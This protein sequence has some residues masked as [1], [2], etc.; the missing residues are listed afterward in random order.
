MSLGSFKAVRIV[1][2]VTV[3]PVVRSAHGFAGQNGS[4]GSNVSNDVN[5]S[6][7]SNGSND[8]NVLLVHSACQ[9]PAID[10]EELPGDEAGS[11]RGEEHSGP[12]Q[13]LDV[14]EPAHRRPHQDF[15]TTR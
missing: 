11:V 7:G 5:D 9:E 8:P 4:N 14:T 6:N 2:F 13:F 1:R 10:H 15:L 3:V 12:D